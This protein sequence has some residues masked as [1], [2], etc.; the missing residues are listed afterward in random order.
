MPENKWKKWANYRETDLGKAYEERKR[1]LKRDGAA[2]DKTG[3]LSRESAIESTE[4]KK[5]E[6]K[7]FDFT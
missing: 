6:Q 3:F 2:L 5:N 4:R 1:A 7:S